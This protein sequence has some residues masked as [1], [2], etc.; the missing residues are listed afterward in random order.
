MAEPTK[1]TTINPEI[2][3][4]EGGVEEEEEKADAPFIPT[5][6]FTI[7]IHT[8]LNNAQQ[9]HGLVPHND[10]TQYRTYLTKRLA[11]IR[12]AKPVIKSLSHGPKSKRDVAAATAAAAAAAAGSTHTSSKKG[13]KHSFQPRDEITIEKASSHI[14]YILDGIYSI[15]RSWA[16]SMELKSF[17]EDVIANANQNSGG[18]SSSSLKKKKTSPGKIRQHYINQLRK[19][20][21]Y[22]ENLEKIVIKGVCD[23]K[24]C[25][26]MNCYGAWMKG[27]Y[28][29]EVNQWEVSYRRK[30]RETRIAS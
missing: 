4:V 26:E 17:Y 29:C 10:Y 11:R 24:T 25:L 3:A 18:S 22:V 7:A 13:G 23:E 28:Y 6:N 1:S 12:H 30:K 20:V 2:D 27:N 9:S 8:I 19:A 21:K 14:N 15:E 16:H 5:S